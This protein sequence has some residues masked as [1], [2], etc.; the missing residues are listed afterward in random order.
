MSHALYNHSCRLFNGYRPCR[1]GYVCK[2]C[3]EQ[4]PFDK[5][6]LLINLDAMG[7]VLM[8]TCML[9]PLRRKYPDALLTWVTLPG[10]IPVLANNPLIDRIWPYD[11]STVSVLESMEF[12]ILLNVDK[13]RPS[14]SLAMKV[15]AGEKRGFGLNKV[16]NVI[17]LNEEADYAYRLGLDDHLKFKRNEQTGQEILADALCLPY[18]KDRYQLRL[19]DEERAFVVRYRENLGISAAS[20]AIGIQTGASDLYPLKS[21]TEDQIVDLIGRIWKRYPSATV[22]LLGGPAERER[23]RRI[24]DRCEFGVIETPT[25]EGLRRGMLYINAC[26]VVVSPDTG[27][28]HIAIAL[29]KWVV[30][31]FNISCAQEID[32][33]GRGVKVTTDLDC[34]PCWR[35]ECHDPICK[36]MVDLDSIVEGIEPGLAVGSRS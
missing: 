7:D 31:W 29:E 11:F 5:S 34:S 22:L 15:A 3:T 14:C 30:G 27:A 19:T 13:G 12:D 6:I 25:N 9:A 21:L 26:D 28:L 24:A 32:M 16:G 17:A 33:F 8:T 2:D 36:T 10:H 20:P 35:Q 23:N 1:P 18:E 4:Q